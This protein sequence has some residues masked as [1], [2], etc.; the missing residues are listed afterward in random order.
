MADVSDE[1][2]DGGSIKHPAKSA[3]VFDAKAIQGGAAAA[4]GGQGP[5][6]EG[7][8]TIQGA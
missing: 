3:M 1:L 5:S 4:K 2:E 8:P 6:V 7:E